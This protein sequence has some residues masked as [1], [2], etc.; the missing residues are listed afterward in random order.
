MFGPD[1]NRPRISNAQNKLQEKCLGQSANRPKHP[2][3]KK[4]NHR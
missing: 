2:K 3:K 1:S 4:K